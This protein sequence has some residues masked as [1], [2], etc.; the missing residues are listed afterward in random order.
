M[1]N[2]EDNLSAKDIISQHSS[3]PER[4]LFYNP[5]INFLH[6]LSTFLYLSEQLGDQFFFFFLMSLSADSTKRV[7]FFHENNENE[8]VKF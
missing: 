5:P 1:W 4:V 7:F 6:I 3:E 2:F 8:K